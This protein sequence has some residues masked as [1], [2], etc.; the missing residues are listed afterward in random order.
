MMLRATADSWVEVRQ[1]TGRVL[2]RRTLRPGETWPVPSDSGLLLSA[3]N[4]GGLE[5]VVNGVATRVATLKPGVVRDLPLEPD[6]IKA[7]TRP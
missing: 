2:L 5:L 4:P 7:A 3:G 6:A 1:K